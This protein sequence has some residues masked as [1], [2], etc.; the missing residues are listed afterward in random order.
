MQTPGKVKVELENNHSETLM[1]FTKTQKSDDLDFI[2]FSMKITEEAYWSRGS[3]S[4]TYREVLHTEVM[5]ILKNPSKYQQFELPIEKMS[6]H[7]LPASFAATNN[8]I[9][10]DFHILFRFRNGEELSEKIPLRVS[11][12]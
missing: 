4:E 7:R 3:D 12:V 1:K 9:L 5:K 2:E 6:E 11:Y 10:W 8:K